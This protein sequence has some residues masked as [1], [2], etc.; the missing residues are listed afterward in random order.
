M[1]GT[2]LNCR[3][4]FQGR[5]SDARAVGWQC[6]KQ[7]KTKNR[8]WSRAISSCSDLR[9]RPLG[10]YFSRACKSASG[11]RFFH[12]RWCCCFQSSLA[13]FFGLFFGFE[14]T[15]YFLLLV[16]IYAMLCTDPESG[17]T[18]QLELRVDRDRDVLYSRLLGIR[19]LMYM[20]LERCSCDR[21]RIRDL[22]LYVLELVSLQLR[23]RVS[24]S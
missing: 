5:A 6:V 15:F 17:S 9:S 24:A 10:T 22:D 3:R 20:Y 4:C 12:D 13:I 23:M 14:F 18:A 1:G 16:C 8:L 11:A 2:D 19:S 7:K 21:S